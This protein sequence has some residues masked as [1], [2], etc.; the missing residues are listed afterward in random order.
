[1]VQRGEEE[2]TTEKWGRTRGVAGGREASFTSRAQ[3]LR[4]RV[5]AI[6]L[7]P[8]PGTDSAEQRSSTQLLEAAT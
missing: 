2:E 1:V 6:T 3:H 8:E 4:K 5:L 7:S